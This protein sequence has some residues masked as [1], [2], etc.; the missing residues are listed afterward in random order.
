[1]QFVEV[2]FY[3]EFS[4]QNSLFDIFNEMTQR[5]H[6]Q[7]HL[8]HYKINFILPLIECI[9]PCSSISFEKKKLIAILN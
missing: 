7:L 1:M 6:Y 3:L 5:V 4:E 2:L 8:Y 9:K